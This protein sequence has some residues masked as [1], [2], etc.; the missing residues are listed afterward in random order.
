MLNKFSLDPDTR[1]LYGANLQPPAGYVFDAGIATTFS[2]DFETALAVPVSLALFAAENR[3]EI[4]LHPLALLEAAERVAGRLLVFTDVGRIHA[5]TRPHSRLCSL[6]ERFM[7]EVAAPNGGAFHPKM[8]ALR[9]R[10]TLLN[11]PF[12]LRLVVMSRNMTRDRS[13]DTALTLDG[14]ATGRSRSVNRPIV[15]LIRGL[16]NLWNAGLPEGCRQLVDDLTED[17]SRAEWTLP[18]PFQD[19]TFAVNGL[20]NHPWKPKK[21]SRLGIISPFCDDKA[22]SKLADLAT[23][24]KP[25]LVGRP[26]ELMSVSPLTLGRFSRVAVMDELAATEDGEELDPTSLQGLHAKAFIAEIGW[27]TAITVGSANATQPALL[28][29]KNIELLATI[30]G[31]SSRVGSIE[32]ILGEKGFGRLTHPFI[33]NEVLAPDAANRAAEK[34]LDVA[35]REICLGGLTLRC[36]RETSAEGSVVP[37]RVWLMPSVSLPLA[38]IAGLR[39]WLVTRGEP[40]AKHA[41]ESLRLGQPVDLDLVPLADLTRFLALE[42]TDVGGNLKTLF[43][44]GLDLQGLPSERNAA[45]LRSIIENKEAFFRYLRL[46]LSEQGD[47]FAFAVSAQEG[48]GYGAWQKSND[49]SPLLEE[50]VRE[51]CRGGD[52]LR[53]IERLIDRLDSLDLDKSDPIPADFRALWHTFQIALKAQGSTHAK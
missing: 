32:Q 16:P 15:E 18:D 4:L 29:S 50:L 3:D 49:E 37:W 21:C 41:L 34:R 28:S 1:I 7:V 42:L 12:R 30:S 31:K 44:T 39:V 14:V 48:S 47:P 26:D 24:E 25:I 5:Q 13:W 9:Y 20:G 36:E 10:S 23:K 2:L 6:L 52:Q 45:I 53:A 17:L 51:F 8:W 33:P 19:I 43:S 46:L 40:H 27:D 22:L 35:R 38:G 11:A